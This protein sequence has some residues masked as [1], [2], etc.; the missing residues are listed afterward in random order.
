[1]STFSK[2]LTVAIILVVLGVGATAIF[3]PHTVQQYYVG[4]S[5]SNNVLGY[6]VIKSIEWDQDESVFCSDDISK[7]M[8]VN[9][10]LNAG[11]IHDQKK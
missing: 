3:A 2:V 1:M 5:S 8:E 9:A 10:L 4:R 11:L 6:C 7:V